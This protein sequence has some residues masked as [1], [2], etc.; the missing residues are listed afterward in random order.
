V[1]TLNRIK[2]IYLQPREKRA[3]L[4]EWESALDA[5]LSTAGEQLCLMSTK[6]GGFKDVSWLQ[7]MNVRYEREADVLT[8]HLN[9]DVFNAAIRKI[10]YL[11]RFAGISYHMSLDTGLLS[12]S[13]FFLTAYS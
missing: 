9:R 10:S 3:P 11:K 1:K 13:C 6:E 5:F 7:V 4:P 8:A 12:H 2:G